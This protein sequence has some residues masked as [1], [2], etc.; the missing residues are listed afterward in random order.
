MEGEVLGRKSPLYGR[1]T[2]QLKVK[3]FDCFDAALMLPGLSPEQSI[4]YYST[5]GGTPYYLAQVDAG[6]TY[7]EN[8]T[9]L[10]FDTSGV[11]YEEPL[12]LLRQELR[13]PALYNSIL[14]AIGSGETSPKRIAERAG[15]GASSMSKYL[16]TLLDLGIIKRE[17]PF[18][19]NPSTSRRALYTLEDPFFSYWYAFVSKS[20]G[21]IEA[22]AGSAAARGSAFGQALQTHVGKQFEAVCGQWVVRANAKGELP[23]LASSFGRWWGTDSREKAETD[24]DLIAANKESK[25]I[26]LGECKWRNSFNES[27]ALELLEHRAPLVKGYSDRSFYLFTKEPVSEATQGKAKARKDLAIVTADEM[28]EAR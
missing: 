24:I 10:L 27:R 8:V 18:G 12:M 7:E 25:A 11:L 16:K 21:A 14:D 13:E 28:F 15:V 6:A 9:E 4:T 20:V 23:F 17:V 5:F 3:P 22:G 19:E 1:R 2:M 26:L